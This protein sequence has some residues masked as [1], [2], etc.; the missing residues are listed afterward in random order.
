MPDPSPP[1]P[2]A[3]R[4]SWFTILLTGLGV[5]LS[6][7]VLLALPTGFIGPVLVFGSLLFFGVIGF[8][9]VVWGRWLNRILIE[10]EQPEDAD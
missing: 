5:A 10:E 2:P 3:R 7:V 6:A 1:Q 4:R 8:H 9:Y